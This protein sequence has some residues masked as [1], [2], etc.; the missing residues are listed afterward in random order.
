MADFGLVVL[1]AHS[2]IHNKKLIESYKNQNILLVEPVPYNYEILEKEYQ[3]NSNIF[4]CKNG[5]IDISKKDNFYFV[6]KNSIPKLGKHWA[7]GIGSFDKKHLINHKNKRFKIE[8]ND[9]EKIE[10][11]FIT[12]DDLIHKYS[13]KL[14][15][16][17]QIDIEGAEF[18]V[19]NSIDYNKIKIN[20]IFFESKHFDGT[21]QEGIKLAKIKKKLLLNGFKLEQID[22]ENILAKKIN[23]NLVP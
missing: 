21:F 8:D 1:G 6:K 9:I 5:V 4:I 18:K 23:D 16:K 13:I 10:I 20:Q 22:E 12:F 3:F 15:D 11:E 7:S 14:I 17:L 19:M 2:G